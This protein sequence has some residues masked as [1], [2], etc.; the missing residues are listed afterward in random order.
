[1]NRKPKTNRQGRKHDAPTTAIPDWV[2]ELPF[3]RLPHYMAFV[4]LSRIARQKL[5]KS[6]VRG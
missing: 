1:M 2:M 6:I 3:Y 5:S 4:D